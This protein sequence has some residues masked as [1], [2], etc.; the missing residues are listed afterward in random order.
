[1]II[2]I[3]KSDEIIKILEDYMS[4]VRPEPE[5]RHKIDLG[6]QIIGQSVILFEI[7]PRW[8]N[9][10][11]TMTIKNAKATYV[12]NKNVWKVFWRRANNK[13]YP[14]T[15]TPLVNELQDFLNLV[16]KDECHCFYG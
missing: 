5:I 16:E 10:D 13:W 6:Y 15:P 9:P 14:Y 12:K 1:M 2:D 7:Y 11:E 8:D 3:T 4:R